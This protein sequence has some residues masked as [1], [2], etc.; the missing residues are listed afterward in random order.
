M[1]IDWQWPF[2]QLF[3]GKKHTFLLTKNEIYFVEDDWSL[4]IADVYDYA[5]GTKTT[6]DN[7]GPWSFVDFYDSYMFT[8]GV[9][10]LWHMNLS[11][12]TGQNDRIYVEKDVRV[13]AGC[14]FRG[15]VML[16]GFDTFKNMSDNWSSFITTWAQTI[17]TSGAIIYDLDFQKNFLWWSSIG[18][19]DAL[20]LFQQ[21]VSQDSLFTGDGY[22]SSRPLV[23]E[24]IKKNEMG[25]MPMPFQKKI[26]VIKPIGGDVA[27]YGEDGMA[28]LRPQGH[29]FGLM[30]GGDFSELS[31]VGVNNAS[32]VGGNERVHLV[33]DNG[34][35]L[36]LVESGLKVTNLGYEEFLSPLLG[37]DVMISY[38]PR[39][40]SVGTGKFHISNGYNS[41]LLTSDG[42]TEVSQNVTTKV[43]MGGQNVGIAQDENDGDISQE[44]I[45]TSVPIS[46]E[47]ERALRHI[48]W[49]EVE[50]TSVSFETLKAKLYYRVEGKTYN[51]DDAWDSTE[52]IN[53]NLK[54][55]VYFG[56]TGLEFKVSIKTS[57]YRNFNLGKIT[58]RYLS[59][60][61]TTRRGT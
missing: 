43:F 36:W 49:V 13:A 23:F 60:D 57:D 28:F 53:L 5:T 9:N 41:F 19:E 22:G 3:K 8:N 56:V 2:P 7:G 35:S 29:L 25:W 55:A 38:T 1:G 26:V 47:E 46:I 16:G 59:P 15:R 48:S 32:A 34:G 54:G 17:Q 18:G 31:M 44:S 33:M 6:I 45:I 30:E 14:G 12:I 40:K 42:M 24:Q 51:N 27:V 61:K 52:W 58:V 37:T 21:A 10:T 20:M 39:G 11:S 4:T 50:S